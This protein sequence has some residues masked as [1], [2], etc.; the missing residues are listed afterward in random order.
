VSITAIRWAW[1]Q[2]LSP[3]AKLI[4]VR[5][6]DMA[7]E[8]GT[9]FPSLAKLERDTGLS[10]RGITKNLETLAAGE[11]LRREPGGPGKGS[12]RYTLLIGREP[13]S[14][15]NAIPY[16]SD[17]LGNSVPHPREP[18]SLDV[19][20]EVPPNPN[21]NPKRSPK[22]A[23]DESRD[24]P[25]PKRFIQPTL[26]EVAEYCRERKNG[27]S[28]ERWYDHYTAN[29]WRVG[30]NPMKNWKAAVRTWEGNSSGPSRPSPHA[31]FD[32][33]DYGAGIDPDGRF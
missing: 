28:P 6:A 5:L 16:E 10:R 9:C 7:D 13:D 15:G 4:L 32:Q 21:K 8:A 24:S 12:T 23:V 29:G 20:N 11:F 30:K 18:N 17:S 27:V 26:D 19:G 33:Q 2:P 25:S 1:T 22:H 14:L 31:N 3:T